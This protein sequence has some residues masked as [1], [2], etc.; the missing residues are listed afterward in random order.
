MSVPENF[1]YLF[2]L[3]FILYWNHGLDFVE[4]ALLFN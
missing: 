3:S 2:G 4:C 1:R